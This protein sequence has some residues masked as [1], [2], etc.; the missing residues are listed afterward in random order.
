M[1]PSA[2]ISYSHK[3][4][5]WLERLNE[6]LVPLVR[7]G[8]TIWSDQRIRPGDDWR[9]AIEDELAKATVAILLVSP[10]FLAS[11]FIHNNE[12]PP[13]LAAA[14]RNGLRVLWIPVSDCL[15]EKTPIAAYQA[16]HP[17]AIPLDGL[18]RTADRNK[19]LKAIALEIDKALKAIA[20]DFDQALAPP[21]LDLSL[22][23]I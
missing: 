8:L 10:A 22:I 2:F 13:L 12:L 6:M 16:V 15:H 1:Q 19:A 21:P 23:H 18:R 4:Q 11:D 3:D 20:L 9:T 5:K 14:R 7:G 17:P